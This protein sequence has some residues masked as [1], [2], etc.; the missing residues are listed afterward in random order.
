ML[1][2]SWFVLLPISVG[3]L[4]LFAQTTQPETPQTSQPETRTYNFEL[5][6]KSLDNYY[7]PIAKRAKN[8]KAYMDTLGR[9]FYDLM[10]DVQYVDREAIEES[11][12]RFKDYYDFVAGLVPEWKER[13][14]TSEL[15]ELGK[16]L[17][18]VKD[19]ADTTTKDTSLSNPKIKNLLSKIEHSC[20]TCHVQEIPKVYFR[21]YWTTKDLKMNMVTFR[22]VDPISGKNLPYRDFKSS[23]ANDY[24]AILRTVDKGAKA[25][26]KKQVESFVKRF[27]YNQGLCSKCHV[28]DPYLFTT[29][30]I[31][32]LVRDLE[33]EANKYIPNKDRLKSLLTEIYRSNCNGCHR[34]HL[35]ATYVQ[36]VLFDQLPKFEEQP[37]QPPAPEQPSQPEQTPPTEQ[38]K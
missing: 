11:Y 20:K 28:E 8:Y 6:P 3:F 15:E 25:K 38:S 29:P 21:Y 33:N 13:F 7:P 37:E 26:L 5:P 16:L 2:R 32:T 4:L 14:L 24:Y 36:R 17:G 12:L 19:S 30:T 10:V 31:S 27:N 34:V 23:L 22:V 18:I 1:K 35:P 9:R